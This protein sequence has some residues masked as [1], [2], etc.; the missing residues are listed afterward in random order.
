MSAPEATRV[1]LFQEMVKC[2]ME[3]RRFARSLRYLE[4]VPHRDEIPH[5]LLTFGR[6]L[7]D[8]SCG[9]LSTPTRSTPGTPHSK[10]RMGTI[11]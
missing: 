10:T 9:P 11:G 5:E 7:V 3:L 8:L 4:K 6:A 2:G 1:N